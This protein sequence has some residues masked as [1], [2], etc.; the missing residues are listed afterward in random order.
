MKKLIITFLKGESADPSTVVRDL[1]LA[2]MHFNSGTL[3]YN[4]PVV[5]PLNVVL[6][7]DWR[8]ISVFKPK[9]GEVR[10]VRFLTL[11]LVMSVVLIH[12]DFSACEGDIV[13]LFYEGC[14]R[15]KQ[16]AI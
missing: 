7:E 8:A 4:Y 6:K 10:A 13:I 16:L 5:A 2:L 12:V 9:I 15:F 1:K 11:G 14:P 3:I